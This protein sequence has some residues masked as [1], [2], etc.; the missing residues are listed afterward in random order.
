MAAVTETLRLRS[1]DDPGM[2]LVAVEALHPFLHM[3]P[4]LP[5]LS[6]V[7]VALAEAV[8]RLQFDLSMRFMTLVTLEIGHRS[9]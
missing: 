7:A 5:D 9:L 1:S 3:K 8:L 2:G 6:L 4:V